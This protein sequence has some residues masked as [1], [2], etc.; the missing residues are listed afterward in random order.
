MRIAVL[1]AGAVGGT[2]AA[3]LARAGH[4]LEVTARGEHLD[5]IR[6]A[7]LQLDGGWGSYRAS[8]AAGPELAT[9]PDL[10]ILATKAQDA[11]GALAG[12]AAVL[13]AVPLLVV[14]NGLGGL[15]V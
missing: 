13:E 12:S 10:A 15:R 8:V 1:G 14:Q 9:V 5:A 2:L 6:S 11:A 4:E 3:L 7:G